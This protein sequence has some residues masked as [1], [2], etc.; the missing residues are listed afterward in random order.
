MATSSFDRNALTGTIPSDIG[1]LPYLTH[2]FIVSNLLEG[3]IP[4][5]LGNCRN[6]SIMYV[7]LFYMT[8]L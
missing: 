8:M 7:T 3:T 4:A 5:S 1:R 2:L 6:L